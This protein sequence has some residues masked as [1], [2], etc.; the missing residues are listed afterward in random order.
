LLRRDGAA[1]RG[2]AQA[3]LDTVADLVERTGALLLAPALAEW[4]A[5]LAGLM[6]CEAQRPL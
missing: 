6:G 4:R 5:E 2:A 1:A 3:A